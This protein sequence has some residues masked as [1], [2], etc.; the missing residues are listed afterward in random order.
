MRVRN[1]GMRMVVFTMV[2]GLLCVG[3]VFAS[4]TDSFW[5]KTGTND[6]Y[7]RYQ[8]NKVGIG[9][10]NP[11]RLL[12]VSGGYIGIYGNTVGLIF[13]N[14]GSSNKLWDITPYG[15]NLCF[16]ETGVET[17]LTI[18]PGGSVGLGIQSPGTKLDVYRSNTTLANIQTAVINNA[19][20][21]SS[22][23]GAGTNYVPGLIWYDT[24]NNPTKPKAG[25]WMFQDASGSKL[26][27]GTSNNLTTGITNI[28]ISVAPSGTVGIGT[29]TTGTS[30]K[31]VVEGK[32]GAREVVVTQYAWAD[33]VFKDD[34][35][36]KPLD[37]VEEYIKTHKHLEGIPTRAEVKKNGVPVGEMQ[38][39]LLQKVEELTLYTIAMKKEN[40]ELRIKV[41]ELEKRIGR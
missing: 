5:V 1:E 29:S 11:D 41:E 6:I 30:Y 4:A 35:N 38:A 39:K 25:I 23:Y 9:L 22:T 8:G 15:N 17:P 12:T 2:F 31:L 16:N 7:N 24:D 19:I 21:V 14:T 18:I 37:K 34:Y 32:I 33:H 28:A 27:F 20:A 40:D 36:L 13:R 26:M 3:Q 10:T